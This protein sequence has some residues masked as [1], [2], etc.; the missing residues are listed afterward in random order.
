[1]W[2]EK[3]SES[4][5]NSWEILGRSFSADGTANGADFKINTNT[6]GDQY[7]PKIAAIGNDCVVVWT[8]LGQDGSWEGVF[9][10]SLQGGTTPF[11][12]EFRANNTTISKQIYPAIASNGANQFLVSWS[13]FVGGGT[14]F[15]LFSRK[16]ILNQQP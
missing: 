9:G 6:Y 12:N 14:G 3:D 1:V 4:R 15:D 13:S 8:S 7:R 5:S 16:Y 10:R 2:S 11:G